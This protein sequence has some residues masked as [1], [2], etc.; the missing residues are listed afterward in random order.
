MVAL[1]SK[2]T[3]WV[4]LSL[5]FF[6]LNLANLVFWSFGSW[7]HPFVYLACVPLL[8][9]GVLKDP[10]KGVM[11]CS[12]LGLFII[13]ILGTP[14]F[15]WDAKYIWFFHAKR[16]F[17]DN[18][19]Y[20]Q[21]DNYFSPSHNDYPVL[22]PALAAS[23]AKMVGHWNE[24]YPRLSVVLVIAPVF[25]A[26][27]VVLKRPAFYGLWIAGVLIAS[28]KYLINGYMD[29]I[30][31]ITVGLSCCLLC[32][33]YQEKKDSSSYWLL[34]LTLFT[35]P[36]IKNE[37]LLASLLLVF[38]MTPKMIATR[39][40]WILPALSFAFYYF[41][42][43]RP[44]T[45]AGIV[46]TDLFVPGI[47]DRFLSRISSS[48]EL[49]E[50]VRSIGSISSIYFFI[51]FLGLGFS[52]R[53][54]KKWAPGVFVVASY[55]LAMFIIYLITALELKWHLDH[56]VDRTFLV[57]NLSIISLLL[58]NGFQLNQQNEPTP[59]LELAQI[60]SGP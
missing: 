26:M 44:V 59:P 41:I 38:V 1:K 21:L 9:V 19:L 15:D 43:K 50:I 49:H 33:F 12:I 27:K 35:L 5:S 48:A 34:I 31:G 3:L 58:S 22:V 20:T 55:S 42:W 16:I 2:N 17:L 40:Y 7:L 23:L 57:V 18:H 54:Y 52:S 37:G 13:L 47:T 60:L 11:T 29:A 25:I 46:V 51:L 53:N 24:V 10:V 8:F 28:G 14:L 56:S 45:L 32:R 30:L 4:A 39:R 6:L 36:H